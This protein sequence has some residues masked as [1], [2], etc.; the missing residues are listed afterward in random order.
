MA[1]LAPLNSG[2]NTWSAFKTSLFRKTHFILLFFVCASNLWAQPSWT[3]TGTDMQR[4]RE[5][6]TATLLS[7]GKVLVAGGV[8]RPLL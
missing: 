6:H 1:Q 8:S 5:F 4:A 3:S 7:S 2:L